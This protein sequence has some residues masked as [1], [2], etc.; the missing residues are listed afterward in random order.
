MA[1]LTDRYLG[2]ELHG[3]DGE[4]IGTVVGMLTDDQLHQYDVVE[5]GGFL[6][7]GKKT[8]Y[9]V[10]ADRGTA[11]GG[12]R[13]DVDATAEQFP[14]LGWDQAPGDLSAVGS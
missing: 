3:L 8:T 4:K 7:F 9:Y 12:R 6:G 1:E 5:R 14:E 11:T 10:P 2:I 13:L